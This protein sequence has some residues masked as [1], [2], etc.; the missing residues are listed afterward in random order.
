MKRLTKWF[1]CVGLFMALAGGLMA[2]TGWLMGAKIHTLDDPISQRLEELGQW[3]GLDR[4]GRWGHRLA[5]G[6][7]NVTSDVTTDSATD[8]E[9]FDT[10]DIDLDIGD[11]KLLYGDNYS[12]IINYSGNGYEVH[13]E[14]KNGTLRIWSEKE[15]NNLGEVEATV[16][17]YLP[18]GAVLEEADLELSMGD[19]IWQEVALDGALQCDLSMGSGTVEAPLRGQ[20]QIDSGMGDLAITGTVEGQLDATIGMGDINLTVAGPQGDYEYDLSTG[21]G[22]LSLNGETQSDNSLDK[23]NGKHDISLSTG[24]GDVSLSFEE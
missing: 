5:T 15:W 7:S 20:I 21:M 14:N 6:V 2:F 1:I 9:A 3:G 13:R 8:V 19:L 4:M 22:E 11:V 10:L 18:Q 16:Y 24:M 23:D 17:I 12:V